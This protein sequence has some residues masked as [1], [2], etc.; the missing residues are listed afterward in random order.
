MY[1]TVAHLWSWFHQ[2]HNT[3]GGGFGPAPITFQEVFAWASLLQIEPTPWEIEQLMM[4][5]RIWFKVQAERDKNKTGKGKNKDQED[6][7]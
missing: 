3:R 1:P 2:L 6:E 4:L 5:D 7:D